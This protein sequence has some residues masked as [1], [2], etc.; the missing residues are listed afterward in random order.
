MNSGLKTHHLNIG[1]LIVSEGPI[2]ISTVLGSC[3]S[4]CLFSLKSPAGGMIH[5]ALPL[6]MQ[7]IE[8]DEGLRYGEIAIPQ[9]VRALQEITGE[10]I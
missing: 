4:V 3:V 1:E 10:D 2:A 9:L 8:P 7:R 6:A 5:Y